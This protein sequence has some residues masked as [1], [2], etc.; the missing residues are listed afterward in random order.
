MKNL[1][2]L[3]S[4]TFLVFGCEQNGS[5]SNIGSNS[6][7]IQESEAQ[8]LYQDLVASIDGMEQTF[9]FIPGNVSQTDSCEISGNQTFSGS[10]TNS[11]SFDVTTTPN[12][13]S[14]ITDS[15]GRTFNLTGGSVKNVASGNSSTDY[16]V[17]VTGSLTTDAEIKGECAVNFTKTVSSGTDSYSGKLCGFDVSG[18]VLE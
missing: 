5:G 10:G 4:A 2:L 17:S 18:W 14:G 3:I 7:N 8:D 16:Q 12:N 1:L 15:T 13:C 9:T 11:Y 6:G